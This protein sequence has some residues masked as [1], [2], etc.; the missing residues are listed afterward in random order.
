MFPEVGGVGWL[1]GGGAMCKVSV[2][3][4][5]KK[6]R[7]FRRSEG[8]LIKEGPLKDFP[9]HM[10]GVHPQTSSTKTVFINIYSLEINIF[11]FCKKINVWLT[12]PVNIDFT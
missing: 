12:E 3:Q 11:E 4:D 10:F 5:L 6:T 2:H 7:R 9:N 1:L 8:S